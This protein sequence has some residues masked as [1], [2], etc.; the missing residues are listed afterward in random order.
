MALFCYVHWIA[1]TDTLVKCGAYRWP[2]IPLGSVLAMWHGNAPL[3]YA[4]LLQKGPACESVTKHL[5]EAEQ[6]LVEAEK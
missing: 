4:L 1:L 5:V 2:Q 6:S 3:L